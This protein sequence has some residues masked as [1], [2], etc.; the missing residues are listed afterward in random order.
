MWDDTNNRTETIFK[1]P[2]CNIS[3]VTLKP[4]SPILILKHKL[5]YMPV[6]WYATNSQSIFHWQLTNIS[7]TIGTPRIGRVSTSVLVMYRLTYQSTC[8]QTCSWVLTNIY[9]TNMVITNLLINTWPTCWTTCRLIVPTNTPL[10]G[11]QVTQ[12]PKLLKQDTNKAAGK[13]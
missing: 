4:S 10:R 12:D 7:L 11:A 6:D 5:Y 8:W 1:S 3:C 9:S 13:D 2:N